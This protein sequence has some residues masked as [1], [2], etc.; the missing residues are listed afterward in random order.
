MG[1]VNDAIQSNLASLEIDRLIS[2]AIIVEGLRMVDVKLAAF[3]WRIRTL[4]R[5]GWY[6]AQRQGK[7]NRKEIAALVGVAPQWT[8][9]PSSR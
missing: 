1:K 4:G 3:P 7:L 9:S 8:G 2:V 6:W 5:V